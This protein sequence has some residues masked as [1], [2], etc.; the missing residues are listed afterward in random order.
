ARIG[1]GLYGGGPRDGRCGGGRGEGHDGGGGE[2][3]ET[4]HRGSPADPHLS[5]DEGRKQ[6]RPRR[7]Q[8]R[9]RASHS[10]PAISLRRD[11][12][13]SNSKAPTPLRY[14]ASGAAS[15]SATS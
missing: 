10:A 12:V 5:M 7:C 4:D 1:G 11:T 9:S 14:S 15:A 8:A 2:G 13:R 6:G 3:R